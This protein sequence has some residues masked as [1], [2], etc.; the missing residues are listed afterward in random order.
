ME[1]VPPARQGSSMDEKKAHGADV[2]QLGG[3]AG[4]R[5]VM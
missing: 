3:Q 5:G 1:V 2:S 4:G